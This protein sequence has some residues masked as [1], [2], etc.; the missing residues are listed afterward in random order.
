MSLPPDATN[1][2]TTPTAPNWLSPIFLART[3]I[4]GG[5]MGVANLIPGVSGGTMILVLGLYE[6]FIGSVADLSA[7]RF[8]VR[9]L[10][11][12]GVLGSCAALSIL[13]LS[14]VILDLLFRYPIA[15]F[16]LFIG[17]TLGG[18]PVLFRSLRPLRADVIIATIIG[19]GLMLSVFLLKQGS[20]F[21]H[22]TGMDVASGVVGATTMV[23]P[24]VSGSYMLLVMNQYDR[25]VGVVR[26]LKD[27]LKAAD[28]AAITE[29]LKIVVPVGIGAVAGII[30]L[31]NLLKW[32]LR[33]YQRVTLGVLLGVLL[34][35]VAGLWPFSQGSGEKALE[36]QSVA[37]LHAY[38]ARWSIAD[39]AAIDD[40]QSLVAHILQKW[41]ERKPP[42]ITTMQVGRA[43]LMMVL[44]FVATLSLSR[45]GGKPGKDELSA[46][47]R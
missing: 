23:L 7:L 19:I 45:L 8:S 40:P 22:N 35:S 30:G 31:S 47:R 10:V 38:A 3:V 13:L 32:L 11:F 12:L 33:R 43:L 42:T 14:G 9:R 6:E 17:L 37:D 16:A 41:P 26:N 24:G 5:L 25:V 15:M 34:G 4:G 1:N 20:G 39:A 36:R 44:G 46:A 27:A 29:C 18:A 21:P 2:D 28:M